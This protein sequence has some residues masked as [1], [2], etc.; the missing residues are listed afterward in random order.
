M[1]TVKFNTSY[2]EKRVT[3]TQAKLYQEMR[4]AVPVLTEDEQWQFIKIADQD[5]A[6][7]IQEDQMLPDELSFEDWFTAYQR[8]HFRKYNTFLYLNK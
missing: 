6:I 4:I 3:N 8:K 7:E 2:E 1:K 5:L